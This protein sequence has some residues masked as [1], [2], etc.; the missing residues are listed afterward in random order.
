[1]AVSGVE[2]VEAA[3]PRALVLIED[4]LRAF[5][6]VRFR[7][8][9]DCMSPAIAPGEEVL[10]VSAEER[11][12]RFGDVVLVAS[13]EGPRL[14]RLVY[15]FAGSLR[16]K[17]DRAPGFDGPRRDTL[18]TVVGVERGPGLVPV[19]SPGRA[20]LSLLRGLARRA[21]RALLPA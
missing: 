20:L 9:G 12:P 15:A 2:T 6:A 14:H 18:G 21:R 1:L 8:T 13:R 4:A 11:P 10:V 7:V 17:G 16:T 3:G 19:F 5:G